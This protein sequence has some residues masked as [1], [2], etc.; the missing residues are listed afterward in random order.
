MQRL[1]VESESLLRTMIHQTVLEPST[2][3]PRRGTRRLEWIEMA[4]GTLRSKLGPAA[5]S[6]LVCA[7]ASR[8]VCALAL[9]TGIEALL[10]LRDICGIKPEEAVEVSQWMARAAVKQSLSELRS[11]HRRRGAR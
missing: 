7:L 5:Y 6:R 8:L 2:G 1:A 9:S 3:G 11:Q 4:M 10:V